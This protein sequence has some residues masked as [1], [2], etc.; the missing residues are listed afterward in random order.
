[1]EPLAKTFDERLQEIEAYLDLLDALERQV[2]EGP[3]KIGGAPIT[4]QQQ[5]ILYSSVYLQLYNLMEATATWCMDGVTA[6]AAKDGRWKPDDL[7][8]ALKREWVRTMAR[9][10]TD[11]NYENRLQTAI[12]F[13]DWLVE[14]RPIKAWAIERGGGGNW[15]DMELEA[16]AERLGTQ[17]RVSQDVYQAVKQNIRD[18]KPPLVLVKSLRNKLAHGAL[19]FTECG[20]NVTVAELREIKERTAKYLREVVAHFQDFIDG[21]NFLLPAKRPTGGTLE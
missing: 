5:K 14:A 21:Y 10:H 16:I 1:L 3:P 15:D 9:T 11:L 2:R 13:F 18:D 7:S 8:A 19:S 6:A 20:E 12:D 17:L 4:A